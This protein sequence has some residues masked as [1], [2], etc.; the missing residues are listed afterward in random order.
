MMLDIRGGSLSKNN[1]QLADLHGA[2]VA[3]AL[4]ANFGNISVS[5]LEYSLD[6]I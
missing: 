4:D 6:V 2:Q 3:Q 5:V 1:L